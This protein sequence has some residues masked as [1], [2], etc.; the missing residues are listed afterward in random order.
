MLPLEKG[1]SNTQVLCALVAADDSRQRWLRSAGV[2]P[3][4]HRLTQGRISSDPLPASQINPAITEGVLDGSQI[5]TTRPGSMVPD[6]ASL[7]SHASILQRLGR[8]QIARD[9]TTAEVFASA[10]GEQISLCVERQ[11]ARLLAILSTHADALVC[12][13]YAW[14]M[15]TS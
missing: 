4:L 2:L 13:A 14:P 12:A 11:T 8:G 7:E 1:V 6:A 3:L 10:M 15:S 9:R 5:R